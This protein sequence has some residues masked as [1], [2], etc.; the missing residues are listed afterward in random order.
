MRRLAHGFHTAGE[1]HGCLAKL[2][3]LSRG[4]NRLDSGTAQTIDRQ[5]RNFYRKSRAKS[6]VA[7]AVESIATGLKGIPKYAVI[8]VAGIELRLMNRRFRGERSQL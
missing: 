3:Q 5:R 8:E 6:D 2:D 4:N 7:S 1:N